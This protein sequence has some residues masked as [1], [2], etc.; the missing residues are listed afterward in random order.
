MLEQGVLAQLGDG[1]Q[2]PGGALARA[3]QGQGHVDDDLLVDGLAGA[4]LD[5]VQVVAAD[6]ADVAGDVQE[7]EGRDLRGA[8]GEVCSGLVHWPGQ[9]R[10]AMEAL[11]AQQ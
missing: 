6:V 2:G 10:W 5:L 8:I 4:G 9:H 11:L 1:G 7:A 3:L